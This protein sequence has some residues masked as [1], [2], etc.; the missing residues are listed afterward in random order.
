VDPYRTALPCHP[1]CDWRRRALLD[2]VLVPSMSLGGWIWL[3]APLRSMSWRTRY[4]KPDAPDHSGEPVIFTTCPAC[5][6]ELPPAR[7]NDWP[8]EEGNDGC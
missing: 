5:G 6:G 3:D 8:E 1:P 4:L 2:E 7:D